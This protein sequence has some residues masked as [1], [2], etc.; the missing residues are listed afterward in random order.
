MLEEERDKRAEFERMQRERE[1]QLKEAERKVKEMEE[2]RCRLDDEL[3]KHKEKM[4][5]VNK[6]QEVLEAKIKVKEQEC[7]HEKE[8]A[9]RLTSL[10]PSASFYVRKRDD[11][12]G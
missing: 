7:E 8:A 10:N 1:T 3:K 4:R 6:G 9:S 5:K 11:R 12:H 2:E